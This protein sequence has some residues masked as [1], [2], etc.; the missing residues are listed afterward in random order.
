MSQWND[1]LW[2][3]IV[4]SDEAKFTLPVALASLS[5]EHVQDTE[6]MMA[7]SV[8][9]VIPVLILFLALQRHYIRGVMMGASRASVI[10][11]PAVALAIGAIASLARTGASAGAAPP[12]RP[13]VVID[14][15]DSTAA[16]AAFP[17]DGVQMK[18]SSDAGAQGK[19]LR[20]DFDF[21][22][23]GGY[24]VVHR[25]VNL[26]LPDRYAFALTM[27]G[28]RLR[29]NLEI[30]LIDST[31]ANVWWCNRRDFDYPRAWT[32]VL[33]R[34]RQITFAWG[35]TG[36]GDI[37]RVAAIEFAVTAG[38][39]GKG[40]VWLDQLELRD[41]P[42]PV[43]GAPKARASSAQPGH[44]AALAVD[45]DSL[46]SWR[47]ASTDKRPWIELDFGGERELSGLVIDWAKG[48]H[49]RRYSVEALSE[50]GGWRT[51]RTVEG[52]G[53]RDWIFLPETESARPCA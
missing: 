28:E 13:P 36:G 6:L 32:T 12:L 17:A 53:G 37:R 18:L 43:E 24:A 29:N 16:W 20:I 27:R 7:G 19:A 4:L 48:R 9:T 8:V 25:A 41:L 51:L 15:F 33:T 47:S 50:E 42:P 46:T 44:G 23:G 31:G 38:Q 49:P 10:R 21:E 35:P 1:F 26:T 30:K 45:A 5:G 34:H 39:G 2:P 3:L 14:A 40:T 11:F 52:D 22:K